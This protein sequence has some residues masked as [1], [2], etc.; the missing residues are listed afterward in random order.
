VDRYVCIDEFYTDKMSA[1]LFGPALKRYIDRHYPNAKVRAFGDPAG[2]SAGQTVETTPIQMLQAAGVPIQPAPSNV[3]QLRRRALADPIARNCLDGRPAFMLSP[4]CERIREGLM[5]GF[6]FRELQTSSPEDDYTETPDKN[7][8]SHICE[9]LEY[10]LL[11]MGEGRAALR[12][13][14]SSGEFHGT[15]LG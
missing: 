15:A 9:A 4:K 12:P 11:G 8:F 14:R 13:A 7:K 2:D 6:C 1:S 3:M 5:G 10:V